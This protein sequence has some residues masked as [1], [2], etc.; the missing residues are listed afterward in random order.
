MS[1]PKRRRGQSLHLELPNAVIFE[2][3]PIAALFLIQFDVKA[4]YVDYC[5]YMH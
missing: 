4:G 2:R 5:L 1:T 3:P